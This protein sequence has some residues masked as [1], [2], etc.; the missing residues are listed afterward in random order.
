MKSTSTPVTAEQ[1]AALELPLREYERAQARMRL[2]LAAIA[3]VGAVLNAEARRW[4]YPPDP[5]RVQP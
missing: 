3:P 4:D 5:D 2:V 1:W